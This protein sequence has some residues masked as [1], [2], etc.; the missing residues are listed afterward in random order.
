MQRNPRQGVWHRLRIGLYSTVA[1]IALS[2]G[3][4][5]TA[6]AETGTESS[7][8]AADCS[9]AS[10]AMNV[11]NYGGS[12]AFYVWCNHTH[13]IMTDMYFYDSAG[14]IVAGGGG[15]ITQVYPGAWRLVKSQYNIGA[16]RPIARGCLW[17]YQGS[18]PTTLLYS[19]CFPRNQ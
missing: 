7:T 6:A 13:W 1:A 18:P 5:S 3:L 11:S 8:S 14:N 12:A 10:V 9:V 17:V 15:G 19:G 2:M 16:W 4:M